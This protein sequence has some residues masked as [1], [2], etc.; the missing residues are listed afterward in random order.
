MAAAM[1]VETGADTR[2]IDV[3][4]LQ[5]RLKDMGGYLPHA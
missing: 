3:K 4:E 2:G 1:M 5:R